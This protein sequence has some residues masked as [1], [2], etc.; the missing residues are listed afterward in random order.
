M[1]KLY[2]TRG[3]NLLNITIRNHTIQD[4]LPTE[5]DSVKKRLHFCYR[6]ALK[7][8]KNSEVVNWWI[9]LNKV[10]FIMVDGMLEARMVYVCN[11]VEQIKLLGMLLGQSKSWFASG[12]TFS[13]K[14]V[15]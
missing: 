12:R 8:S 4:N 1:H 10:S 14:V 9:K 7:C 15:V 5:G 13:V 11:F 3:C 6:N 2:S